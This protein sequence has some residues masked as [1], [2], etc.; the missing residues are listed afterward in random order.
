MPD[1][2]Q[3]GKRDR[4]IIEEILQTLPKHAEICPLSFFVLLSTM[5]VLLVDNYDSFTYNLYD[6]LRQTGARCQVLRNDAEE[7]AACESQDF[8]AVVLSPGPRRPEGAGLMLPLIA[9]WHRRIL[10]S[11]LGHPKSKPE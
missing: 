5:T 1:K 2:G 11:T 8:D 9:A 3:T 6:Y 4:A 7:L 10:F